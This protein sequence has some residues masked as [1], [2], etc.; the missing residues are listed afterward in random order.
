VAAIKFRIREATEL[1]IV[2]P[3]AKNGQNGQNGQHSHA[4]VLVN[5]VR[6]SRRFGRVPALDEVSLTL[7]TGQMVFVMGASGVGKTTLL[8]LL[9]GQFRPSHGE[10]WVDGHPFHQRWRRGV[11]EVRRRIGVVFQDHR[12]LHRLTALENVAFA[13]QVI[14]PQ[15]PYGW[16]RRRAQ[17]MLDE[18]ELG[19]RSKAY[20]NQLSGGE[21]QRVAVARALAGRPALLLADEPTSSLD[22]RRAEIVMRLLAGAAAEGTAVIVATHAPTGFELGHRI[23]RLRAAEA[24]RGRNGSRP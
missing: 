15:V 3:V 22:D 5:V 10:V 9:H 18:V 7:A 14:D 8:R 4:R 21:R 6:V 17:E 13:L 20:P 19:K 23:I 1:P 2:M 24:A 16:V 12:L 11:G